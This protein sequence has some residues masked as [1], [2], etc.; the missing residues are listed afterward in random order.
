MSEWRCPECDD[1]EGTYQDLRSMRDSGVD[2]CPQCCSEV[3]EIDDDKE[4]ETLINELQNI[5]VIDNWRGDARH[6]V[7]ANEINRRLAELLTG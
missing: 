1:M 3:V 5:I 4:A 6:V 2:S 7:R